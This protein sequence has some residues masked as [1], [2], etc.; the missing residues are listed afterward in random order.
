MRLPRVRSTVRR[1]MALI[2][3]V[4]LVLGVSVEAIRLK[5]ARSEFLT[6]ASANTSAETY[7]RTLE[8]SQLQLALAHESI[9]ENSETFH[10]PAIPFV[11]PHDADSR[12]LYERW[13]E[14]AG[15]RS[16]DAKRERAQANSC[17]DMA[18]Y[19]AA[20]KQKYLAAAARPWR[21]IEPDPPPPDP[22]NRAFY[23]YEHG[24]HRR[25]VSAYREALKTDP[26]NQSALNGLAW[27]VATCP[28]PKYRNGRLAVELATRACERVEWAE[29]SFMDTLSTA[30]AEAGDFES[31]ICLEREAIANL[32][33]GDANLAVFRERLALFESHK[34][35]RDDRKNRR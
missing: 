5:R 21:S 26:N 4:A 20:L 29:P 9:A 23:W 30:Y 2:A 18:E 7:Y 24:D 22:T 33:P 11:Y 15:Q 17:H 6:R 32:L 16:H 34:P 1:M 27:L 28:D 10:G 13:A 31:A 12:E 14:A 25:T 35:Y 8:Q 3:L 19:H